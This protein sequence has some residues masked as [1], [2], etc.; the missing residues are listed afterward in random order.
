[1]TR[2][3]WWGPVVAMALVWVH[4]DATAGY[5]RGQVMLVT[6]G[7][8]MMP[9]EVVVSVDSLPLALTR[10]KPRADKASMVQEALRFVPAVLPTRIG[11]RVQF[12]NRDRVY[13]NVFSLS[14][15]RRF[16]LGKYPP[17]QK[18]GVT[19]DNPGTVQLLCDIHPDETGWV[20][21]MPHRWF[22]Q[23]DAKGAFKLPWLPEGRYKLRLWHPRFGTKTRTLI[24]PRQGEVSMRLS[25]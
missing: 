24:V 9:D 7:I 14:R 12:E 8:R 19:F 16:D 18:H 15:A 25:F 23:P 3:P 22:T 20:V 21:V 10:F 4:S 6:R 2:V 17:G 5:V 13:H 11:T 1:M